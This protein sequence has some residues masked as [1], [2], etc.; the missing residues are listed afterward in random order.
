M[1]KII[2]TSTITSPLDQFEINK[3][4]S[5]DLSILGNLQ[6]SITNIGLYLSLASFVILMLYTLPNF[7][8]I[9]SNKWSISLESLYVTIHSIVKNQIN[10]KTDKY[11]FLL[12]LL[13]LFLY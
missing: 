2:L 6:M 9:I 4:L 3:L 5:L 7:D 8:N 12:F 1:N 11:I 10:S 13:C